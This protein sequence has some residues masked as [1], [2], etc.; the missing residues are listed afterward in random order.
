VSSE[1]LRAEFQELAPF[2]ELSLDDKDS[3]PQL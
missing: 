2:C 1:G 3:K